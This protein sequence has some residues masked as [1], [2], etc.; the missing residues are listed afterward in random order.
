MDGEERELVVIS[1]SQGLV[2]SLRLQWEQTGLAVRHLPECALALDRTQL[3]HAVL[4]VV[5]IDSPEAAGLASCERLMAGLNIPFIVL[6]P[7]ADPDLATEVLDRGAYDCVARLLNLQ[8]LYLR[9]RAILMRTGTMQSVQPATANGAGRQIG[10]EGES[11][12]AEARETGPSHATSGP[13]RIISF[14]Y[15]AD[16]GGTYGVVALSLDDGRLVS[17]NADD[18]FPS[19]SMYKLLVMYRVYQEIER[20][21][22]SLGD[23]ITIFLH[24]CWPLPSPC[25]LWAEQ[26][27]RRRNLSLLR[28]SWPWLRRSPTSRGLRACVV[29]N[30][31]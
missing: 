27:W 10:N 1:S 26:H 30:P 31:T 14:S 15:V 6:L 24:L 8:E 5:D 18:V 2:H 28:A 19:A 4:L 16:L 11:L 21:D 17:I 7:G 23:Q 20:G 3:K 12:V 9:I 13:R 29:H 22:L 25:R